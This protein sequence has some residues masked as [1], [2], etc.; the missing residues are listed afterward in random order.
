MINLRKI[1]YFLEIADCGSFSKAAAKLKVSQPTLSQQMS[2]LETHLGRSLLTRTIG[3][4]AVTDAGRVFYRHAQS[5]AKQIAFAEDEVRSIDGPGLGQV[6]LGL[7]TCGAASTLALPILQR[8]RSE[9]P[10]FRLRINDN[11]AGTLSDFI[12]T[13]R[14]DLALA[15]TA[16]PLRGVTSEDL[17]IEELFLMCPEGHD[18]SAGLGAAVDLRS[19]QDAAMVLPSDVHF[20]RTLVERACL[21][22]GFR[23][24]IIAEIDSL[25]ALIEAVQTGL[26]VS[27]LPRAALDRTSRG[28]AV[29]PL[30]PEPIE[31]TVSLCTSAQL[32]VTGSI[33]ML[34]SLVKDLVRQR[35]TS[36]LWP[37]VKPVPA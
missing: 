15:Y 5:L 14:I 7:A 18:V 31:A 23:P 24:R 36:G 17:F 35:L 26:G 16:P 37:G 29:Y 11:F 19:L 3:G 25:R 4:V 27:I 9:Y 10:E 30:G 32:P 21:G 13:G 1:R 6:T 34:G 22:A 33:E 8:V 12:M 2:A 28:I 20:I